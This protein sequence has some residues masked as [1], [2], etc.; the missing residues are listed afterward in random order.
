MTMSSEPLVLWTTGDIGEALGISKSMTANWGA[1]GSR[2]VM[3]PYA[4]T[5]KG[6]RLWTPEQA[7]QIMAEYREAADRRAARKADLE[8]AERALERMAR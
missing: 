8:R 5:V 2:Q 4:K 3:A 7:A 6:M 1:R